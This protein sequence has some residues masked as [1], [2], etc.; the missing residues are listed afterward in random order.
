MSENLSTINLRLM[1]KFSERLKMLRDRARL[2]QPELAEK[3]H[4]S[5]GAVGNWE[6]GAHVPSRDK[7]RE[8]SAVLG[9][10]ENYLS[11]ESDIEVGA[12]IERTTEYSGALRFAEMTQNELEFIFASRQQEL[13]SERN[14]KRRRELLGVISEVTGELK[15]RIPDHAPGENQEAKTE[16]SQ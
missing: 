14:P 15:K 8:I 7:L 11:G 4:V 12:F 2:T 13:S 10:T 5:K 6:S 1:A 16:E 3:V 9:T